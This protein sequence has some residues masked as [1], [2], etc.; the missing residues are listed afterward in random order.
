MFSVAV[1]TL[2]GPGHVAV[3]LRGELDLIDA[4]DVAVALAAAA[5]RARWSSWI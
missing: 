2:Q 1:S 5:R 4:A 3:A